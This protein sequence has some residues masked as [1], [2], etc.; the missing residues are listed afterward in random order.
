MTIEHNMV[1]WG[2]DD[3]EFWIHCLQ[4][5]CDIMIWFDFD[6]ST[7][8]RDAPNPIFFES[9]PILDSELNGSGDLNTRIE[10]NWLDPKWNRTRLEKTRKQ[11]RN[12]FEL[13]VPEPKKIGIEY[14]F[15]ESFIYTHW[16]GKIIDALLRCWL[17]TYHVKFVVFGNIAMFGFAQ[18]KCFS[19]IES[20]LLLF[21]FFSMF[22]IES[23]CGAYQH[24]MYPNSMCYKKTEISQKC[25]HLWSFF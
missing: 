24:V 4:R 6:N 1:L 25:W 9:I 13:V 18:I 16:F 14:G 20:K 12:G 5:K 11:N 7:Y 21:R 10:Q 8:N 3:L 15:D 17:Y 19:H 22:W 23:F 2:T